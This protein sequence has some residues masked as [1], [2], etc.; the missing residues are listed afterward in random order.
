M[1]RSKFVPFMPRPLREES[2]WRPQSMLAPFGPSLGPSL[3][4]PA[5]TGWQFLLF[6]A[7]YGVRYFNWE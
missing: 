4:V 2:E 7:W 1:Q 6:P 3:W 5:L